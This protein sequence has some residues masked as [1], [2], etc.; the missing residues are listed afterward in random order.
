MQIKLS[1]ITIVL[2]IIVCLNWSQTITNTNA[3]F[4]AV[5]IYYQGNGYIAYLFPEPATSVVKALKNYPIYKYKAE[6]YNDLYKNE[7]KQ[8][9]LN[10]I[11]YAGIIC[12]CILGGFTAGYIWRT[13]SR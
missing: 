5:E 3:T 11:K 10:G 4:P 6:L 2:S 12:G 9:V 7:K 13:F 1:K 8:K